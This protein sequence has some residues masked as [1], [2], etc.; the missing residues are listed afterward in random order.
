MV[1]N[2][3]LQP[4]KKEKRKEGPSFLDSRFERVAGTYYTKKK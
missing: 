3:F 2:I 1:K 4:E